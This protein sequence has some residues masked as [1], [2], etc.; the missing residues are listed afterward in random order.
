MPPL[1]GNSGLGPEHGLEGCLKA[2][3]GAGSRLPLR[4]SSLPASEGA[5]GSLSTDPP[6]HG[7]PRW[8]EH[9]RARRRAELE[10]HGWAPRAR[11]GQGAGL[12]PARRRRP[13]PA[14][15]PGTPAEPG[16]RRY[17]DFRCG[18][19]PAGAQRWGRGSEG[20]TTPGMK[21]QTPKTQG[22]LTHDR[23]VSP[24]T[25]LAAYDASSSSRPQMGGRGQGRGTASRAA[26]FPAA[27]SPA[28][29]PS[30]KGPQ[31]APCREPL[32][33]LSSAQRVCGRRGL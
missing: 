25:R 29:R 10:P 4:P 13:C 20:K 9:S 22:V 23:C 14:P 12:A 6:A 26:A 18:V 28:A 33:L 1:P 5:P 21:E 17:G 32:A 11:R 24:R 3:G 7:A 8:A 19:S 30:W 2:P 31:L 27:C 16:A 15:T